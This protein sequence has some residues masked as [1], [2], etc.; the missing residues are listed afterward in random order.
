MYPDSFQV[1]F[2]GGFPTGTQ[3][4]GLILTYE[5]N[6]L[7]QAKLTHNLKQAGTVDNYVFSF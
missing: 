1:S 6:K 4:N 7:K 5:P 2:S 3:N